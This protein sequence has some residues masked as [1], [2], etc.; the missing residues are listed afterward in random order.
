LWDGGNRNF[1]F[2]T[3]ALSQWK[4][5][6]AAETDAGEGDLRETSAGHYC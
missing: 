1:D 5:A 3:L 6:A 2:L 4:K